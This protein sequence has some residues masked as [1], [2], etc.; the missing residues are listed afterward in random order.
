M[1]NDVVQR[2]VVPFD[3]Q[4]SVAVSVPGVSIAKP[5]APS[6]E[7]VIAAA[8]PAGSAPTSVALIDIFAVP[9]KECPAIFRAV[10]SLVA[11]AALPVIVV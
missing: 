9:S 8:L 3:V 7:R 6:P 5:P 1:D 11:V 2:M 10:A 4:I